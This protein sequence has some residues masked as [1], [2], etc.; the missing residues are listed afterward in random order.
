VGLFRS[1]YKI[2]RGETPE[3][4]VEAP[5]FAL[6]VV[7]SAL[8]L[9]VLHVYVQV[10][11]ITI[12]VGVSMFVFAAT[13]LRVELGVYVLVIAMLLSPEISSGTVR[14]GGG[15]WRN[16]TMRYDDVLIAV[17]F[18]GVM[19]KQAF[20]GRRRFF[21]PSPINVAILIYYAIALVSCLLAL[22]RGVPMWD[23]KAAFFVMLKMAEFYM[24]FFLVGT[25][26]RD[27]RQVRRQLAVFFVTA[28]IVAAYGIAMV[29]KEARVG[30]PFELGD[31]EP[32]TLGGYLMIVMVIALSL[33]LHA[34]T[35]AAKAILGLIACVA[36]IPFLYTL[37]RASYLAMLCAVLALT[38]AKR[39]V[40]LASVLCAVLVS[41]PFLM[42]EDVTQRV[43][44]TFQPDGEHVTVGGMS[45][46]IQVD[47][48]TYERIYVWKKVQYNLHVWPWLGGG[49][50]WDTVL[51]SQYARVII[52]TGLIGMAA[53]L[54][55][56][57]RLVRTAYEG[58]RWSRD[59]VVK[60]LALGTFAVTMGLM[61]H[62][63][64]TISF[65]IIRVMEPYWFLMAMTVSMRH[66]AIEEHARLSEKRRAESQGGAPESPGGRSLLSP[67]A[68]RTIPS[69]RLP[70]PMAR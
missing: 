60:G 18:L 54:F 9:F 43:N 50:G 17:I 65:L 10:P 36:F 24:I 44:Y 61:V 55:L 33:L 6:F 58:Y 35:K 51:D 45:T 57:F 47:K 29:G 26:I 14:G 46:G 23:R 7:F 16:I 32:N 1:E 53:F 31:T 64:G 41:S 11:H 67:A 12:A 68:A 52:E 19:V 8:S 30:A 49:V 34:R 13:V 28:M 4:R 2:G 62:S 63:A 22:Q 66:L 25:A 42:P 48:S 3:S 40:L 27:S 15:G 59:W 5:F 39:S 70:R 20:E 38:I 56:Q 37:S 69:S 21:L